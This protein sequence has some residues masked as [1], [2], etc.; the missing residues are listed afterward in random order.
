MK[1]ICRM[2]LDITTPAM[3]FPAMSIMVLAYTNRFIAISNRVRSLHSHYQLSKDEAHAAQIKLLLK[4]LMLIRNMQAAGITGFLFSVLS[5][6][7]ILLKLNTAALI[8]FGISLL[9]LSAS[10]CLSFAEIYLSVH[11]MKVLLD[12]DIL[13]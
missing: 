8:L 3:V 5:I 2:Q 1:G 10:L 11:A 13:S 4:R 7:A 6:A 9:C 12:Q